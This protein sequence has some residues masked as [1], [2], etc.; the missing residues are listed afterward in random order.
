MTAE[1][2][3]TKQIHMKL[4][5]EGDEWKITLTAIGCKDEVFL[6]KSEVQARAA[7]RRVLEPLAGIPEVLQIEV[8]VEGRERMK[9]DV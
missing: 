2:L 7:M 8:H 5:Q 6:Y 1:E 4:Q 9:R 3:Q